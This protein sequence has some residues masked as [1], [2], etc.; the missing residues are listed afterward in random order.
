MTEPDA[1]LTIGT[2]LVLGSS[3][4]TLSCG[5]LLLYKPVRKWFLKDNCVTKET[6]CKKKPGKTIMH[7]AQTVAITFARPLHK[8]FWWLR[9][10]KLYLKVSWI[11]IYTGPCMTFFVRWIILEESLTPSNACK[12]SRLP[13][14]A[15]LSSC[16]SIYQYFP[17]RYICSALVTVLWS[18]D[19]LIYSKEEHIHNTV[20]RTCVLCSGSIFC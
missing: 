6:L 4:Y 11:F 10:H 16:F 12:Q 19:C 13:I 5:A 9:D 8:V 15:N 3:L 7:G 17:P 14:P 18:S 1:S 20:H 2:G